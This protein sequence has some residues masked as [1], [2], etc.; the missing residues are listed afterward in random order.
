MA[1]RTMLGLQ[2]RDPLPQRKPYKPAKKGV[3]C[4]RS[5]QQQRPEIGNVSDVYD[6][7]YAR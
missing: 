4:S 1:G 7:A 2:S 3:F 6:N 5:W